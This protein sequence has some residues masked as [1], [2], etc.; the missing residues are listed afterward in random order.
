VPKFAVDSAMSRAVRK[1]ATSKAFRKVAPSIVPPL[2]RAVH[3]LS[4]GRISV[5]GAIV[6][7]LVLTTIGRK[8]GQPRQSPLACVPDGDRGWYVVGSNFGKESHPAWT[9]NLIANPQATVDYRRRT[10]Q[11]R[12]ELLDDDAKA[13][14]WPQLVAV[15]PAYD[16]YVEAS[17]RNLRVFRLTRA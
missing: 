13:Q 6:P 5:S 10:Y 14:V 11:V 4:R 17:G 8:T 15:W 2:D 1:V 3:R 12:A 9:A 16:D 7:N